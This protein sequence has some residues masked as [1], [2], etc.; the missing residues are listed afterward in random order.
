MTSTVTRVCQERRHCVSEAGT[1]GG[2]K[3]YGCQNVI[4]WSA[5]S[6]HSTNSSSVERRAAVLSI[7]PMTPR[8]FMQVLQQ[9]TSAP[10]RAQVPISRACTAVMGANRS[11]VR[12]ARTGRSRERG[13]LRILTVRTARLRHR[14]A[15]LDDDKH[16]VIRK[17]HR[18]VEGEALR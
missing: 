4:T 7:S 2:T 17:V 3:G 11:A 18:D 6:V 5:H 10:C 12:R 9:A 16:S 1:W 8:A 14:L 15:D 13:L